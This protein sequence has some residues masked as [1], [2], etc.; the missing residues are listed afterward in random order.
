MGYAHRWDRPGHLDH[1]K[2][3]QFAEDCGRI[4][5]TAR[6]HRFAI[7]GPGG[8][9]E[10]S[11]SA[12][13]VA[14]NGTE[15]CGHERRDLAC[16]WPTEDA[17]GVARGETPLDQWFGGDLVDTRLCGGDCSYDDF[18]IDRD[19]E[20]GLRSRGGRIHEACTT[21]F[22][23]YDVVVTAC[24]LMFAYRFG[25]AVAFESDG[26]PTHWYDGQHLCVLALG[27][28]PAI[29]IGIGRPAAW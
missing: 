15:A 21:G 6:A 18:W 4:V 19:L 29:P 3:R 7:A 8:V 13:R 11:I 20:S 28:L 12:T 17:A 26:T 2:F 25:N 5:E 14:F 9:G 22:R 24:L 16:P 27:I 10:P 23:P 1:E